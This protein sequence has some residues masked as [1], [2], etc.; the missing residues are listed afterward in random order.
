MVPATIYEG[1]IV[2]KRS[3]N[4]WVNVL[5]SFT[6]YEYQLYAIG[7]SAFKEGYIEIEFRLVQRLK[8][9]FNLRHTT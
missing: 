4:S 8:F 7:V 9:Q 6:I 5:F 2:H 1:F 3:S